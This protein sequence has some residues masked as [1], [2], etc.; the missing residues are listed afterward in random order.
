MRRTAVL[1]AVLAAIG[2]RESIAPGT[3]S[4]AGTYPLRTINGNPP[5]QIVEDDGTEA[6]SIV[7][8]AVILQ[9]NGSYVDSTEV[10]IVTGAGNTSRFDVARGTYRLSN[11]TVFFRFGESEYSMVRDGAELVQDFEGIELIYRR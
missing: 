3:V 6:V 11:D 10:L 1:V 8:G 9:P 4:P 7:G 2:C 5:P